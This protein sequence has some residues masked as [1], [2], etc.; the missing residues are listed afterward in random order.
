MSYRACENLNFFMI[1]I[2][3]ISFMMAPMV[4]MYGFYHSKDVARGADLAGRLR[5]K[6]VRAAYDSSQDH[7]SDLRTS[8]DALVQEYRSYESVTDY[9]DELIQAA[10]RGADEEESENSTGV[11]D[12]A[13]KIIDSVTELNLERVESM[14]LLTFTIWFFP[15]PLLMAAWHVAKNVARLSRDNRDLINQVKHSMTLEQ[16]SRKVIISAHKTVTQFLGNEVGT[17]ALEWTKIDLHNAA[18]ELSHDEQDSSSKYAA[19]DLCALLY[20]FMPHTSMA[21]EAEGAFRHH[22]I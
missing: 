11:Q 13:N 21:L 8:C 18:V 4:S 6:S 7:L 1:A 15:I 20:Q 22:D 17:E 10:I 19:N 5:W 12:V 16:Q 14:K 9:C 3:L 2:G